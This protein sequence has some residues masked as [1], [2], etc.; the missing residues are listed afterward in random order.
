MYDV[1]VIGA[2]II[3]TFITRELSKFDLKTIIIDKENDIANGTTKAN[4]AIVHAGYDAKVGT[5]KGKLNAKGNAMYAHVCEELDVHFKKIGSFVIATNEEEMDSIKDLYERGCKNNI[6]DM[7]ILS[8]EEVREMEPNLSEEIIG[9][10]YAPTAGIVSPWELSVALAENAADNGAEIKLE[11]EV[12]GIE[13]NEK[14]YVIHTNNG[15]IKTKYIFN[16]AGVYTQEI[17]EMVAPR[18]F[19]IHPR[20][21]QYNVLDKGTGSI[22]NHV[23]F[24]APT[25]FGKGTLVTPTVHG[26]L[27]IGPDA[28]DLEDKENTSTTS[29]RIAF[30]QE[31][32]RKT[33][34][35]VPFNKTITSFAGLR[36][37]SNLGDFI[38]EESKEAKGFINVA[39]IESPGLSAAPAIA[40]YAINILEGIIGELNKRKEF[41]P[42]RKPV[43]R[44]M[45]LTDEEKAEVIKK[46]PRYGRIICR[47]ENITEGE[48]VDAIHRNAG[49]RTVDGIKRRSRPGMGRCQGGF[50]GPRVMEILARELKMD[51]KDIVKDNKEAYILTEETKQNKPEEVTA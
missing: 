13:K 43:I 24:Q 44:F 46:D 25:K 10:L 37:V 27:L 23:I 14:G 6:P 51:I 16:C 28:E 9:A 50:C 2:G 8:Q 40:E 5:L 33:T 15:D 42:R 20:R 32:S 31:K 47:C 18:S 30:I 41:N 38:I 12:L 7:K 17:N 4:S 34:T 49:G 39:G 36:A 45:E 1:V 3:G 48:I 35:K 22:V 21:G 11:T 19:T 26:N 29:D